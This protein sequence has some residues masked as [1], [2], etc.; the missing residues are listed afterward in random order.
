[1]RRRTFV[2]ALSAGIGLPLVAARRRLV[3]PVPADLSYASA[4]EAAGAIRAKQISSLELTQLAFERIDRFNPRLNALVNLLREPALARAREADA[5]WSRGTWWGPL[6]GV[7]VTVKESFSIAGTAATA[8]APFLKNHVP[9][10]D[11][12]PVARLKQAGAVLIGNTNV[13]FMLGDW[14]SYNEIYGTSNNPWDPTRTPGGSSG[15][16]AAA[17]A[18]GL[19]HLSIG[20]DIGGS[21]RV[22]AHFCGIYGHKP[23]VGVV[24]MRGH[25]PPLPGEQ[26][27]PIVSLPVGGPMARSA[28]DLRMALEVLGGPDQ[29]DAKAYRWTLPPARHRALRDFRIGV[30]LDDPSCPVSAEVKPVFDG[31]LAALRRS[32]ASLTQGW[33]EGINPRADYHTYVYLLG[34]YFASQLPDSALDA[35]RR[36]ASRPDSSIG[37]IWNRAWTDPVKR[38]Q[39]QTA[40]R[41]RARSL[42]SRW[43]QN[44]DV[45]LMPVA[46]VPAF[47]HDHS[48]DPTRRVL[49]T[50]AGSRSYMDLMWWIAAATL[51]G[52]PATVAPL[53][54][55]SGGLPVGIQIVGPYLED[56]TPIAF[57]EALAREIG[58]F[59]PPPG[60]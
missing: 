38:V 59:R 45:C 31:L 4:T 48:P 26:G 53:G 6:H 29:P 34:T 17:L 19:G 24:P 49:A 12:V 21:I 55:T 60:F 46:F 1:M 20:S 28:A 10:E 14:Q 41:E 43:F 30:V 3:P 32:G 51:S 33:P 13:P 22:P 54:L 5:A 7:P 9:A 23:T 58:G 56:A 40:A 8:G 36:A 16:T 18:T 57:A 52:L 35:T 50:P 2:G 47:P 27:T 39:Q 11:S 44:H 25:I 42:W 15:G 37:T